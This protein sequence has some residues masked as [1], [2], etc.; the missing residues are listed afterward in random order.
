MGKGNM[1]LRSEK[2]GAAKKEEDDD[3][4]GPFPSFMSFFFS[5]ETIESSVLGNFKC[6]TN[7]WKDLKYVWENMWVMEEKEE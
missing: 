3:E 1:V 6:E 2:N 7:I 4:E 5:I